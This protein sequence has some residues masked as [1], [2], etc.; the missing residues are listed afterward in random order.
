MQLYFLP[1]LRRKPKNITL[2][3][4]VE[5]DKKVVKGAV[6]QR[7]KLIGV[8]VIPSD[9]L[10]TNQK[11]LV[12]NY[13]LNWIM[14]VFKTL[15]WEYFYFVVLFNSLIDLDSFYPKLVRQFYLFLCNLIE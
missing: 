2:N 5:D 10:Q 3:E 8:A 1:K 15:N 6:K 11:G 7:Q 4:M 14:V 12:E 9:I 13:L